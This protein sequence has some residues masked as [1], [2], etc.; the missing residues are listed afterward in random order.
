MRSRLENRSSPW[1]PLVRLAERID[2]E[3]LN[4]RLGDSLK[5]RR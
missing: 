4:E 2:W 1:Y 3:A 5:L